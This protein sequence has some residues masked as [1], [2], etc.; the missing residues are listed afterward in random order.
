MQR[1]PHALTAIEAASALAGGALTAEA[2]MASCLERIAAREETVGAWE[3]LDRDGALAAAR[4]LDRA[5]LAGPLAGL[6]LAVKDTVDVACHPTRMG[7]PIFRAAAPAA[8]DAACVALARAAG[9]LLPGKTVTTEFACFSPGR[10]RNPHDAER[11]PGGSSSGSAAAVADLMVPLAVGTQTAGSVIRP[12]AF[13]GV[14]AFKPSFGFIPRAGVKLCSDTL[15]TVGVFARTVADAALLAS[16]LAS[17]PDWR[18][19]GDR[20]DA[21]PR[22]GFCR[23]PQWPHAQPATVGAFE[24]AR[25]RAIA[26]GAYTRDVD[27]PLEFH[28]LAEAQTCVQQAETA[29]ALSGEHLCR[30]DLLSPSLAALIEAGSAI[31]PE[32]YVAAVELITRCRALFADELGDLDALAIPSAPGSA[33]KGLDST[34]DPVFNRI[35]T[36][37]HVPVVHVPGL[38]DGAGMPLGLGVA[39]RF[40]DDRRALLAAA[41]LARAISEE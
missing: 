29:R 12:A 7:S 20:V 3:H 30:R 27:L 41:W 38:A 4:A 19:D 22:L 34:G 36:A 26:G 2:L 21:P 10:T 23:T 25:R 33:P 5:G 28:L 18:I 17:V 11:T 40:G 13:C 14:V 16:V 1:P 9:A 8:A 39:A 32:R 24:T 37:L 6:P 15:D 31:P 35:W